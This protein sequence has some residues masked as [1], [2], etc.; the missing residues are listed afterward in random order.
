MPSSEQVRSMLET[1]PEDVFVRYMLAMALVSEDE[2][3]AAINEFDEI[4]SRDPD[5]VPAHFQKGQLLARE[6]E[7]DQARQT[8]QQGIVVARR[9]GD[10]HALGEMTEFLETL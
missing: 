1:D 2:P 5:H 7:I 10:Q 9:V 8:L 3:T 6:G 4:L